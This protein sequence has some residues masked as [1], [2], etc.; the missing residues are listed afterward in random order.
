MRLPCTGCVSG[1]PPS[2]DAVRPLDPWPW[3]E[4]PDVF[5]L[6]IREPGDHAGSEC[7]LHRD[8]P[9]GKQVHV[10]TMGFGASEISVGFAAR[11]QGL[12][13]CTTSVFSPP[14]S[15]RKDAFV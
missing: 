1:A 7:S 10:R 6:A 13:S 12:W 11:P 5:A 15:D 3:R 8:R 2:R 4:S 14:G 9:T